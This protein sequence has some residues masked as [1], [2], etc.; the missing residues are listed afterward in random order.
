MRSNRGLHGHSFFSIK[1]LLRLK[2]PQKWAVWGFLGRTIRSGPSF[3]TFGDRCK[4]HQEDV[5]HALL[6]CPDMKPLWCTRLEWNHGT[7]SACSSFIDVLDFIFVGNK[8]PELFAAVLWTLWNRHNNLRLSKFALPLDKV[9]EFAQERLMG[10]ETINARPSHPHGW[11][12][13][14]WTTPDA[15]GFKINFD[16]ATFADSDNAGLVW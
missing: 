1:R 6:H 13:T 15:N 8:E 4:M 16:D 3:K 10:S 7:L 12:T 2:E 14:H 9:L 5:V 11:S